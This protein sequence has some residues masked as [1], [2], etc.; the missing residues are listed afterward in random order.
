MARAGK[1]FVQDD[2]LRRALPAQSR[3]RVLRSDQ[4]SMERL[5]QA[6]S[7]GT[8]SFT[9]DGEAKTW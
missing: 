3:K 8:Y 7:A 2:P 4:V 1:H 9:P 6:V 5:D